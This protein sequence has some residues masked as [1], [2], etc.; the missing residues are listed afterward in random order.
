MLSVAVSLVG[1]L[2][3]GY[4][5]LDTGVKDTLDLILMSALDVMIFIAGIEIGSNRGI[6][7]R[8]CNLHSALLALAI[9]LAVA[10]G[11]ICGALLLGH[12]AGLSAYDSLLVGGGLGWYSFSSVVISAMYST[13]IGTVAFL[14]NMMRE[15]SGFFL[16]PLLVRVHKFLA[17]GPSGAAT[18]DSG[19]PVV[20]KYTNLH[21]GMY[22]FINGLVL[23]LIVPVLI[24]WLLSLR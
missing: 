23:T 14:A 10:C 15:I 1:G 24:S 19:L 17:L 9:P 16:I 21:V 3:F 7:K 20:I 13:E 12:I 4:L 22:S 11:S 6:L 2:L 8:I 18:M 5:F